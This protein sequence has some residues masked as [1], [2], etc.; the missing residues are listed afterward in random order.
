MRATAAVGRGAG[1]FLLTGAFLLAG[2]GCDILA[3]SP[4]ATPT[5]GVRATPTPQRAEAQVRRGTIVDAIRVLGR[6]VSSREADL[7]FRN[8]GRIREVYVQPG[9]MV[10]AGQ[11]LAELDQRDLPWSL[12]KAKLDV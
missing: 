2:T 3:T 8:S 6:V 10:T 12:A 11:V 9:D 7:S 4:E 1:I 5:P